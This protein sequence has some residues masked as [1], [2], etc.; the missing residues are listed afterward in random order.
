MFPGIRKFSK[1]KNRRRAT[2]SKEGEETCFL[3]QR[4]LL[5]PFLRTFTFYWDHISSRREMGSA[6][7]RPTPEEAEE[8]IANFDANCR[9][10]AQAIKDAHIST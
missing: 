1:E 6:G 5:L 2:L 9:K 10:A 3:G 7:S 4:S 8:L